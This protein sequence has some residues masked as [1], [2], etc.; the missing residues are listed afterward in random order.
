MKYLQLFNPNQGYA[1]PTIYKLELFLNCS[2]QSIVAA[3]KRLEKAGPLIIKKHKNNNNIYFLLQ[4]HCKEDLYKQV[5]ELFLKYEKRKANIESKVAM[6][7]VRLED[8][9][10]S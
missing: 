10:D 1:Y 4:P 7:K 3:N 9:F 8:L 6:D 2:R 5:P